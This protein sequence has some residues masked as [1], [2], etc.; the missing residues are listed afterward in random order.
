[1][2]EPNLR[3]IRGASFPGPERPATDPE[4]LEQ[5]E[6]V[7][8]RRVSEEDWERLRG[9]QIVEGPI[10]SYAL[11]EHHSLPCHG[12]AHVSYQHS[13]TTTTVWHGSFD[14]DPAIRHAF[15]R[16]VESRNRGCC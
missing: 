15:L 13:H 1:M 2:P 8:P 4:E 7:S 6:H 11:C 10:S 12:F 9:Y 16:Q 14:D 5:W 3:A